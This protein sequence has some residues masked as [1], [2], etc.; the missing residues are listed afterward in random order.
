M[1]S[2]QGEHQRKGF[3]LIELLV[4]IAI[5]AILAAI[6]FP[7]F[8]QAREKARQT[9]CLSNMNQIGL[10]M[11]MYMDDNDGVYPGAYTRGHEGTLSTT[12]GDYQLWAWPQMVYS[13]TKNNGIFVCPDRTDIKAP[14][15]GSHT[16]A[17]Y[18][19]AAYNLTYAL[20]YFLDSNHFA[21]TQSTIDV[22][23]ETVWFAEDGPNGAEL[24]DSSGVL[25]PAGYY[26]MFPPYY[27]YTYPNN[28]PYG[29]D[30]PAV[31][32]AARET[33]RHA[34]G[35]NVTWADGHAKWMRRTALDADQCDDATGTAAL[36]GSKYWWGRNGSVNG[37]SSTAACANM[38]TR[39]G[40]G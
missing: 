24:K 28:S 14:D 36:M 40:A 1:I 26:V 5:I 23:A 6:L 18:L 10:A 7:V 33:Y 15:S 8:A 3:T 12:S 34:D 2:L 32:A 13:Y 37:F 35:M 25:Q 30:V 20:N 4:V 19:K 29:I 39:T 17:N 31:N 9:A 21:C 38:P 11:M 22:P 27:E 16:Y